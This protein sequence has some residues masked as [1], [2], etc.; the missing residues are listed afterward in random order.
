MVGGPEIDLGGRPDESGNG[1]LFESCWRPTGNA[2]YYRG[3]PISDHW[4]DRWQYDQGGPSNTVGE[5]WACEEVPHLAGIFVYCPRMPNYAA[6]WYG[7]PSDHWWQVKNGTLYWGWCWRTCTEDDP[8]SKSGIYCDICS[9]LNNSI[10]VGSPHWLGGATLPMIVGFDWSEGGGI[11]Y[12]AGIFSDLL[13]CFETY[14]HIGS[15]FDHMEYYENG[16]DYIF[17]GSYVEKA[18]NL[19]IF[20]TEDAGGGSTWWHVGS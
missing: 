12:S 4:H 3:S 18:R 8:S 7:S 19:G 5:Y 15:L 10:T 17:S 6:P 20:A 16:A 14:Y 11:S 2:N 9:S 13:Q 1:G